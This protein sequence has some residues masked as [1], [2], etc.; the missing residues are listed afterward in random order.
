MK[1]FLSAIDFINWVQVQKRFS[2]KVSLD[3]MKYYCEKLGNP[4][5]K[6]KS[7]H[8]TGTN[9]KGSTVAMLANILIHH[10]YHV[11][12]FTS[13]Y[14]K[15]F[16]ERIS[17][18]MEAIP[19]DKMLEIA[20]QIIENYPLFEKDGYEMPSFFE[21]I[22]LMAFI[23]FASLKNLDYAIIEVGMGGRLDSTN[24][25]TPI[26]SIVTNVALDHMSILGNTKEEILAEKLGIVKPKIPVVC[27]LKEDSLIKIAKEVAKKNNSTLNLVDYNNM[28]VKKCDLI[29]SVFSYKEFY[30]IELSLVGFHQIENALIV[31][32][33]YTI[34]KDKLNLNLK[35]MLD[36]L[37]SVSWLGRMEIISNHPLILI[38]G[39]HNIDGITRVCEFI[40]TLE[41]KH[42]TA[43][44]SI[45]HDKELEMMIKEIDKTFDEIIFTKYTYARSADPRMLYNLSSIKNKK[46]IENIDDATNYVKNNNSDFTIFMGSLYLVSEIRNKR[47]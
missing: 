41:F 16:N 44:V 46:I 13:P 43:I 3:K 27:G 9:G 12:T 8:V 2:K 5:N 40:R 22:T 29:G 38:D 21:F 26:L 20:N 19:D 10:G 1:P 35:Y 25:I 7:I 36:A 33:C 24:V 4:E 14:I 6:F 31:L 11:G 18:D 17:F 32:E 23:Y 47:F 28:K 34:L 15:S 42:K 37:A 45:S 39:S 30:N